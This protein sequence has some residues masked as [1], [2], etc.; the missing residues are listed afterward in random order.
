MSSPKITSPARLASHVFH[1]LGDYLHSIPDE[2]PLH[3]A[4]R[5]YAL[6]LSLSLGPSLVPFVTSPRARSGGLKALTNVLRRELGLSGFAFA[7][8]IGVGGGAAL[9]QIW[10]TWNDQYEEVP[11]SKQWLSKLRRFSTGLSDAHRTFFSYMLSAYLAIVLLQSRKRLSKSAPPAAPIP[12]TAPLVD[13]ASQR[14]KP[15]PT[16]DLTLLLLVR[17]VDSL[18]HATCLPYVDSYDPNIPSETKERVTKRRQQLTTRLDAFVFWASSARIMWCFFYAP[19]RLPRSYNKWIMTLANIDPRILGALRAIRSRSWSYTKGFCDPP[20]LVTSFARDLGYPENW[21][22]PAMLPAYGG[23]EADRVWEELGLTGRHG[24]GG[25]PCEIVH[26]G[27]ASSC[28]RN[29]SI[30][31]LQAFAEAVAIYLPVHILPIL[32]TRPRK[33]LQTRQLIKTGLA[34]VRSATFLSTFVSSIWYTVCLT[35]T[36]LLARLFPQISHDLWDGPYGCTFLGSLVCGGSIWIEQGRRRGEMS[37]YVLPRAI[38]AWLPHKWIN[39]GRA[40]TRVVERLTF[41]LSLAYLLT[42]ASHSMHS[43]RGLSRWTLAFVMNGPNTGFWKRRRQDTTPP[44]PVQPPP[45]HD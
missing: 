30:R 13:S 18:I 10:D 20:D 24:V 29:A 32:L 43:L 35:R 31:G 6:S 15:S 16:L 7:I 3:I 38:R 42:A 4:L 41:V 40:S 8:T 12:M 34:V 22:N 37:L 9:K 17:A 1:A 21:G 2:H 14:G 33:L 36:L 28:T 23:P 27:L 25:L 11:Q 5:T 44:T 26:G 19:D 45:T 39:S